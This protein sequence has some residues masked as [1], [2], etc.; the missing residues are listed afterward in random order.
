VF[1]QTLIDKI[2]LRY[3][4]SSFSKDD[5]PGV[6]LSECCS[7]VMKTIPQEE[8]DILV[9]ESLQNTPAYK[10]RAK[11]GFEI[12]DKKFKFNGDTNNLEVGFTAC[13]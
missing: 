12:C 11:F 9:K 7:E 8:I 3:K 10:S 5:L 1:T 4:I 6:K 13:R 2:S